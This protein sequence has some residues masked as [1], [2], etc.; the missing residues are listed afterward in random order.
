M[1]AFIYARRLIE[2]PK[3]KKGYK[4]KASKAKKKKKR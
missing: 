2:M 4:G 1:G 3:K